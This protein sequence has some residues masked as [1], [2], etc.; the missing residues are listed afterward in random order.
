MV[1]ISQQSSPCVILYSN[2]KKRDI[3]SL[4]GQMCP[5]A[6]SSALFGKLGPIVPSGAWRV[7][8]S[9][10][11]PAA[12]IGG[13]RL[14][15]VDG[16]PCLDGGCGLQFREGTRQRHRQRRWRGQPWGKGVFSGFGR[17]MGQSSLAMAIAMVAFGH[18]GVVNGAVVPV[19][20]V[21]LGQDAVGVVAVDV[22]SWAPMTPMADAQAVE[23]EP[24][25]RCICT[26]HVA[27]TT[28]LDNNC[29]WAVDGT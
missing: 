18:V 16:A 8:S 24:L 29:R 4:L 15:M 28:P 27:W 7:V 11:L 6:A 12:A 3:T 25:R 22:R 9:C 13:A 10:E 2:E 23:A 20:G 17:L 19:V 21:P 14:V 1:S 26:H 5:P